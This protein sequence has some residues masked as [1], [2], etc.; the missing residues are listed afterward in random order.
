[1]SCCKNDLGEFAHNQEIDTG[2]VADGTGVYHFEFVGPNG[3]KFSKY[4]YFADGE[5]LVIPQGILN[6]DFTYLFTIT[7]P[8]GAL[9]EVD[10]CSNFGLKTFINIVSCD[11]IE[12]L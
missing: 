8:D 12:Y 10:E 3:C 4:I 5:G 7:G 6:E 1:M 11:D 2:L 9:L